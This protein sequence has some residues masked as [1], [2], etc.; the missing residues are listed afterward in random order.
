M[1]YIGSVFFKLY[2]VHE[3]KHLQNKLVLSEIIPILE[4][5]L[6]LLATIRLE[7]HQ[8]RAQLALE[9]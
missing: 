2:L 1:C 5:S 7:G 4:Y 3:L 6:V 8:T 9:T